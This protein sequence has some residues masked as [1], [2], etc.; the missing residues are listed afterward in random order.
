MILL[1]DTHT[2]LWLHDEE[3]KLSERAHD[4]LANP[5]N[6]LRLSIISVWEIQIKLQSNKLKISGPVDQIIAQQQRV[7]DLI[8]IDVGLIHAVNIINL[9]SVHKDPFDRM[10]ISQAMVEDMTV[11]TADPKFAEYGVKVLW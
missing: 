5:E 7:N 3:A 11:V 6:D 1:L 10:L 8:L 4:A 2:F 9:P